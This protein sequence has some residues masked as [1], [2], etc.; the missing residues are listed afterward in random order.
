M[1]FLFWFIGFIFYISSAWAQPDA[2]NHYV[3]AEQHRHQRQYDAAISEYDK[4][5][6]KDPSNYKFFV[7]QGKCYVLKKNTEDARLCFEKALK[8]KPDDLEA[9]VGLARIYGQQRNLDKTLFY[10][11]KAFVYETDPAEKVAH[12]LQ[13]LKIIYQQQSL[14]L[15]EKHV[16]DALMLDSKNAEFLFFGAWF[17]NLKQ[18]HAV[19]IRHI[20]AALPLL[21][22]NSPEEN[23]RYY[24]QLGIAYFQLKNYTKAKEA[25]VKA[26]YGTFKNQIVR[27]TPEYHY[28]IAQ[29]FQQ[30]YL[31]E[32]AQ[33]Y[34]D[35]TLEIEP[36][37][38]LARDLKLTIINQQVNHSPKIEVLKN[39]IWHE[40]NQENR[41]K[42]YGD[43]ARFYL[44]NQQFENAYLAAQECLKTL[45]SRYDIRFLNALALYRAGKKSEGLNELQHLVALS[46]ISNDLRSLFAFTLGKLYHEAGDKNKAETYLKKVGTPIFRMAAMELLNP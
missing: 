14:S 22:G 34:L 15:A 38:T 25:L 21:A 32:E 43:L 5:I 37:Y 6:S 41:A 31:F 45:P 42:K 27:M 9:L 33:K 12:K 20:E 4:A 29:A 10:L 44:E 23:A 16:Q 39:A 3:Q 2:L 24:L 13:I 26:N 30:M 11:D 1:K 17:Q 46:S 36:A 7:Q 18:N 8:L 35:K 19:A 40:N 28:A